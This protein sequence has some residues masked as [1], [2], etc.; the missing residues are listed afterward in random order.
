MPEQVIDLPDGK[1]LVVFETNQ[2]PDFSG[3]SINIQE[4]LS[5][6]IPTYCAVAD[7]VAPALN[8]N[9]ITLFNNLPTK[10]IRIQE[11][12]VY[13]RS[14]ANHVITLQLG[15]INS[16]PT[17]GTSVDINR[18]AADFPAPPSPPNTII[19]ATGATATPVSNILFG[20]NTFS[21]NTAGTYIIYE[22]GKNG[23]A[24]QLR[25]NGQDGIV[26]RQTSGAGTTGTITAHVV[27]TLD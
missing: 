21:V 10:R 8:K 6:D 11:V 18:L 16:T 15:Y 9:I 1:K 20:G 2:H 19:A 27:F 23:S 3:T 24:I 5:A 26:L 4:T 12:F 22:K 13:P 14:L 17:G 25:P 7:N